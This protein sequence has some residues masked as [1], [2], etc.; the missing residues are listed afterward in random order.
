MMELRRQISTPIGADE[1]VFSPEDAGNVVKN[2]IADAINVKVTETQGFFNARKVVDVAEGAKIP[3]PVASMG[4]TGV[5][6]A[7]G[8]HLAASPN[9]RRVW[10]RSLIQ[11]SLDVG[12]AHRSRRKHLRVYNPGNLKELGGM[13]QAG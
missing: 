11:W 2:K 3:L 7:A 6:I 1:S 5:S 9:L 12:R 13:I 4:D 8:G 10:S